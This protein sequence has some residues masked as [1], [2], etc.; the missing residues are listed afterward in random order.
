MSDAERRWDGDE[1]GHG[2]ADAAAMTPWVDELLQLVVS[3]DWVTEEP[4][5]QL[6]PY[7]ERAL[8]LEANAALSSVRVAAGVLEL[9]LD[10]REEASPR[11]VREMAYRLVAAIGEGVT[12]V[13][14]TGN[15]RVSA[16]EVVTGTPPATTRFATHGHTLRIRIRSPLAND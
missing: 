14:Q 6:L 15:H 3:R 5:A 11:A 1:R 10:L 16:F 2:I 7:L 9:D 12:L 8:A 4:E 13:R